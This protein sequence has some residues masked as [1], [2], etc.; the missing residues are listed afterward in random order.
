MLAGGGLGIDKSVC[1]C[2]AFSFYTFFVRLFRDFDCGV[3]W[4][5]VCDDRYRDKG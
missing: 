5:E 4:K 3:V 2:D 1:F